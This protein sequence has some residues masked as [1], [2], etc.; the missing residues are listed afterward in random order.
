MLKFTIFS[1]KNSESQMKCPL[2]FNEFFI[3]LKENLFSCEIKKV[4]LTER[5]LFLGLDDLNTV[6]VSG[7]SGGERSSCGGDNL[8]FLLLIG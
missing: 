7:V 5:C 6:I 4:Y 1:K 8:L 2:V 3:F